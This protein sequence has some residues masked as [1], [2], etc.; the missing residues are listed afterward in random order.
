MIL[1]KAYISAGSN[2]GDR[3]ANLEFASVSLNKS[4]IVS[5]VSS[6]FETEPVGFADQPWFLNLAME[7]ET[8]L[9]PLDLLAL[10]QA[11]E[12]NCGRIR[13]FRNAPRTLDLDILLY[14]DTIY[15]DAKLT[16]PHPRMAERRFV[17]VPLA[18]IA[19]EIIHPVLKKSIRLLLETC[20]DPSEI[21]IF[22][23]PPDF[24]SSCDSTRS[25]RPEQE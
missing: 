21:R 4:G 12:E 14:N 11:I 17:L 22:R 18:Q 13:T 1:H 2:L 10:C 25:L 23:H 15:K 24:S 6:W 7:L 5:R 9:A 16:I 19:P 3:A 8:N 20:A